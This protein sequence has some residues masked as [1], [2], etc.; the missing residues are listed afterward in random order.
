MAKNKTWFNNG[1]IETYCFECPPGF[2]RGRKS[3]DSTKKGLL[4]FNDGIQNRQFKLGTQPEGFA[5]GRITK[6]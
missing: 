2:T 3:R 4:W 1:E 5:R 6:K